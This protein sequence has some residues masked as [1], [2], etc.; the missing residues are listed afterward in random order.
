ML[1]I[2]IH[3]EGANMQNL[4]KIVGKLR[5]AVQDFN[6]IQN[7]DKIA[8]GLS[9]GK[10]STLLLLAL[11]HYQRFSPQKFD[12][13]AITISMG[14]EGYDP[15]PLI[16]LCKEIDVEYKIVETEIGSILFDVRKEK[17]PCSLCANMRR[18]ILHDTA[19]E[20]GCNKVALGHHSND[21]AETFLMSLFIEGRL[22]TFSPIIHLS[23]KDLYLIRP[24]VYVGEEEI[25]GAIKKL[26]I[27]I[28]KNPCPANGYTKRQYMKELIRNLNYDLPDVRDRILGAIMNTEQLNIWDKEKIRQICKRE[29]G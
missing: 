16:N 20:M 5:K 19:K 8:V 21:V 1:T 6:M 7:G 10:D 2:A 26:Q 24:F 23:K 28:V 13:C 14:L 15:S 22:N 4:Q 18:G 25:K 17:N 29:E 3:K 11:K 9:G 27:P 12:L